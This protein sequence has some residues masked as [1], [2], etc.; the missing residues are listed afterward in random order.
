MRYTVD[1]S[2]KQK[3]SHIGLLGWTGVA[4]QT[5]RINGRSHK[6]DLSDKWKELYIRSLGDGIIHLLN[7]YLKPMSMWHLLLLF[8]FV[9][10]S[11]FSSLPRLKKKSL[12]SQMKVSNSASWV[13]KFLNTRRWS[14][15]Q[16][17]A[18][19]SHIPSHPQ[20]STTQ[21]CIRCKSFECNKRYLWLP[22]PLTLPL[23]SSSSLPPLHCPG[24]LAALKERQLLA[25]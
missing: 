8:S 20:T 25:R 22:L 3:K 6:S 21:N 11:F 10:S 16:L 17:Y 24:H 13:C 2:D 1:L 9:L 12:V 14:S 15:L 7:F 23:H 18:Q 19:L 4:H 5:S